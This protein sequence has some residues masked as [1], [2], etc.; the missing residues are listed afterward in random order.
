MLRLG[1]AVN[2]W[3]FLAFQLCPKWEYEDLRMEKRKREYPVFVP[4]S[5]GSGEVQSI[6]K[7]SQKRPAVRSIRLYLFLHFEV[8][9]SDLR[10][11]CGSRHRHKDRHKENILTLLL[12]KERWELG[13]N[14]WNGPIKWCLVLKLFFKLF[15]VFAMAL[16]N[17]QRMQSKR[18]VGGLLAN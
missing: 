10:A 11:D 9:R 12:L 1:C 3:A 13:V 17:K 4:H 14:A 8:G 6:I 5:I 2:L 16:H 7:W 18:H 15:Y